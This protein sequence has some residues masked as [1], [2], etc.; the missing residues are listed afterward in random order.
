M[1]R[2]SFSFQI[3]PGTL[4]E[5]QRRLDEIWPELVTELKDAGLSNYT[6][7]KF[8]DERIIGYVECEPDAATCFGKL[9][10]ADAN[11]RWSTWFEDIIVSLTDDEGNMHSLREIWH[12]D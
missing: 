8:D 7:F 3:R 6:L 11:A 2:Q 9:A 4:E 10:H 12:L 1:Q 5:Y